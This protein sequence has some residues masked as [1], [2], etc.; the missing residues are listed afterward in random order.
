MTTTIIQCG[1]FLSIFG[2]IFLF[3]PSYTMISVCLLGVGVILIAGGEIA[4]EI[5]FYNK[6]D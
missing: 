3:V 4:E 5:S 6:Q 2:F 1:K